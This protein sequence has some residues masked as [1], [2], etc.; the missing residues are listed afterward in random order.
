MTCEPEEVLEEDEQHNNVF[1]QFSQI[2]SALL[3]WVKAADRLSLY[4]HL[5]DCALSCHGQDCKAN[6]IACCGPSLNNLSQNI[7]WRRAVNLQD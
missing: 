2:F 6:V 1:M 4:F 5:G 3:S 7:A